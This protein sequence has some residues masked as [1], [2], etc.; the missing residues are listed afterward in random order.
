MFEESEAHK[1]RYIINFFLFLMLAKLSLKGKS[2]SLVLLT[3]FFKFVRLSEYCALLDWMFVE[4]RV[5]IEAKT[6]PSK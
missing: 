3:R 5:N 4:H 2:L 6:L 1:K